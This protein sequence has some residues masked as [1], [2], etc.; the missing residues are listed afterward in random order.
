MMSKIPDDLQMA[1]CV[2]LINS[3]FSSVYIIIIDKSILKY[4][5][6]LNKVVKNCIFKQ[7]LWTRSD[8]RQLHSL[9]NHKPKSRQVIKYIGLAL[10]ASPVSPIFIIYN[11]TTRIICR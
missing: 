5:L 1:L 8:Q 4:F 9:K 6:Y 10:K 7:S 2:K 3:C 11:L